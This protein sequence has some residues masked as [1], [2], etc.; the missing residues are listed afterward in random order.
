MKRGVAEKQQAGVS[1]PAKAHTR[2]MFCGETRGVQGYII[3]KGGQHLMR[4][5]FEPSPVPIGGGSS[6]SDSAECR[7]GLFDGVGEGLVRRGP[8]GQ[9]HPVGVEQLG[10]RSVALLFGLHLH[11]KCTSF[12]PFLAQARA[13]KERSCVCVFVCELSLLYVPLGVCLLPS[14]LYPSHVLGHTCRLYTSTS[15]CMRALLTRVVPAVCSETWLVRVQFYKSVNEEGDKK[16]V[17]VVYVSLDEE[18][19]AFEDSRAH[20]PWLSVQFD[21]PLRG[22]LIRRYRVKVE[23]SGHSSPLP[24]SVVLGLPRLLVVGPQG[25]ALHWLHCEHESPV[26]LREWDFTATQW[27]P[28][29][30]VAADKGDS[31]SRPHGGD[32]R[33]KMQDLADTIWPLTPELAAAW[34][35][36]K[37]RQQQQ[38]REHK[39]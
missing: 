8:S 23:P 29:V 33:D 15:N 31:C 19:Q 4:A 28:T 10:G 14:Y 26:V 17:E 5:G 39:D 20:M 24:G 21:S 6:C 13:R 9:Y 36:E 37:E 27:P 30:D 35:M 7:K 38:L 32:T 1:A 2:G 25:Q 18:R 12:I 11:P 34:P 3:D 22:T 16:K